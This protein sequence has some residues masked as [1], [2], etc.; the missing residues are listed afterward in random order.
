MLG[1]VKHWWD[2]DEGAVSTLLFQQV[3]SIEQNQ[4]R[5]FENFIKCSYL[6]HP[7]GHHPMYGKSSDAI[8]SRVTENYI[9]SNVDTVFAQIATTDVRARFMTDDADWSTQRRARHLETYCNGLGKRIGAV[10]KGRHAFK[11]CALKGVGVVKVWNDVFGR[12][13]CERLLVDNVVVDNNDCREG[14]LPRK[15]HYREVISAE[16]AKAR[17]PEYENEIDRAAGQSSSVAERFWADYRPLYNDDV[18]MIEGWRLPIGVK[19][20]KGYK[21]GRHVIAIDGCDLF[22][23]VYEKDHFPI[24]AIHWSDPDSGWYGIGL[25]ERIAG[26]QQQANKLSWQ[27]DRLIDLWAVPTT[28][29]PLADANIAVRQT[30]RLGNIATYKT[31][32]PHTV[33]PPSV[34]PELINRHADIRQSASYESGV[35]Q[36]AAHSAKPTGIESGVALREYRDQT[37]QRFAQQEARYEQFQLLI[38]SRILECA[39]ELGDSAPRVAAKSKWGKKFIDWG[40][41]DMGDVAVQIA[42]SSDLSKTPAGRLQLALEWAQAGVISQD[43]ARRLMQHPDTERSMSLY[44]AAL[45]HIDHV[46]EDG[47]DGHVII[48]DP[49]MNLNLCVWRGQGEL[50]LAEDNG[51]PEDVLEGV[52]QFV[53]TAAHMIA[54]QS[55]PVAAPMN[56]NVMPPGADAGMPPMGPTGPAPMVP[57]NNGTAMT[58]AGVLPGN[59]A[60]M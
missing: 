54:L 14:S 23:E 39:K 2:A 7:S 3:A 24:L 37:T 18:V 5:T 41:V 43:E 52:R 60:G 22:D 48:P 17:F 19:G 1:T 58:G 59:V 21:P 46:L 10:E 47:L 44:T 25:A 51:A 8:N 11:D 20:R 35:S 57:G 31:A 49:Y 45:E 29:V 6:Y 16:E 53:D 15:M 36:M 38:L 30:S 56:S 9:A 33:I 13:R 55:Q 12:I 4:S 34:S 27:Q 32:I 40:D 26:H 50:Q 28:Y 42:A